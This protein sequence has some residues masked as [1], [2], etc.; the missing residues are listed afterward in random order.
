MFMVIFAWTGAA[1]VGCEKVTGIDIGGLYGANA[2]PYVEPEGGGDAFGL[3]S[4]PP[5]RVPVQSNGPGVGPETVTQT[6]SPVTV[7]AWVWTGGGV[8]TPLKKVSLDGET[9]AIA[10]H[11]S[12]RACR[13]APSR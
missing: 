13:P 6:S 8:P 10:D 5:G 12:L 1:D 3:R 11:P 4:T 7:T 9:V 2:E